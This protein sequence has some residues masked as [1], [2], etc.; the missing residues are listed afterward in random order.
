MYLQ[1]DRKVTNS[2]FNKTKITNI[3]SSSSGAYIDAHVLNI[4]SDCIYKTV[5]FIIAIA[6]WHF[7]Q[8]LFDLLRVTL[9]GQTFFAPK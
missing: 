1:G 6:F 2:G 7:G 8:G 4:Q 9:K 5:H 3:W